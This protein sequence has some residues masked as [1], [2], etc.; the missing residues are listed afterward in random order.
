MTQRLEV[1]LLDGRTVSGTEFERMA[2][3]G[4]AKKWKVGGRVC[5]C[6]L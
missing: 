1:Q 4:A 3:R 2:G 5:V 6:C